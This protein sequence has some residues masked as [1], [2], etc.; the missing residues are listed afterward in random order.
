MLKGCEGFVDEVELYRKRAW[1][2]K[3][4]LCSKVVFQLL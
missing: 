2:L 3:V 4:K 1:S